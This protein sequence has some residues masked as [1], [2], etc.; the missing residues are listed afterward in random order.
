MPDT[1]LKPLARREK[2]VVQESLDEI[3]IYDQEQNTAHYLGPAAALVW[4]HCDGSTDVDHMARIVN[5]SL[6]RT[7]GDREVR[8]ALGQLKRQRLIL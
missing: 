7:D 2:L 3:L 1:T 8:Q 4:R 6:N 5:D